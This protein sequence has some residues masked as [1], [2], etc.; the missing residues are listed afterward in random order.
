MVLLSLTA[1]QVRCKRMDIFRV[2]KKLHAGGDKKNKKNVPAIKKEVSS[3]RTE[4]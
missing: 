3:W 2:I 1:P 4:P